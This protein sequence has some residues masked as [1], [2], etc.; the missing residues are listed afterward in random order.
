MTS[1]F[2]PKYY[3]QAVKDPRSMVWCQCKR[4]SCCWRKSYFGL[5]RLSPGKKSLGCKRVYKVKYKTNGTVERYKLSYETMMKH[6]SGGQRLYWEFGS[7]NQNGDCLYLINNRYYER[8]W[9]LHQIDVND[10]F[11]HGDLQK[12]IYMK[13]PP[14]FA[15]LSSSLA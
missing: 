8:G 6:T 10:I 14:N 7:S 9:K 2:E 15:Y 13:P 11:L 5:L 3:S 12:D 1:H 4:N